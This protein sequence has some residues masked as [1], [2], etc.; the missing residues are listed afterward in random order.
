[1]LHSTTADTMEL[2]QAALDLRNQGLSATRGALVPEK[3]FWYT[4]DF[5]WKS[6]RWQYDKN[7]GASNQQMMTDHLNQ[8]WPL[9]QL[10]TTEACQTLGIYLAPDRNNR[11][12]EQILLKNPGMG[13][14]HMMCLLLHTIFPTSA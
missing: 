6:R 11:L 5:K 7:A 13:G 12:Q 4:I 3:S 2:M 1:M 14:K 10:P 8:W 9:T